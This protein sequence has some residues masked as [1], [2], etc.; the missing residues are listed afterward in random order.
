MAGENRRGRIRPGDFDLGVAWGE[1]HRGRCDWEGRG[2]GCGRRCGGA[3]DVD[4]FHLPGVVRAGGESGCVIAGR[5]RTN[6]SDE[7][8]VAVEL[9][10]G[11]RRTTVRRRRGPGDGHAGGGDSGGFRC[12][13]GC[14]DGAGE[15]GARRSVGR[16][17]SVVGI[18]IHLVGG[19]VGETGERGRRRVV[20]SCSPFAVVT[21][22]A[23]AVEHLVS[24][25]DR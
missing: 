17:R 3:G 13:K 19:A 16:A 25:H 9:V 21:G 2:G 7:T 1:A 18:D 10:S 14:R 8:R 20:R 12:C 24:R 6:R 5:C 15:G 4:C 23:G 11:D 22:G